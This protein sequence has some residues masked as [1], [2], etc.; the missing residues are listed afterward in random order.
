MKDGSLVALRLHLQSEDRPPSSTRVGSRGMTLVSL[1][2][3][4]GPLHY[5]RE[6]GKQCNRRSIEP[7]YKAHGEVHE[8]DRED[9]YEGSQYHPRAAGPSR[10]LHGTL[11]LAVLLMRAHQLE[12]DR[13][14]GS[15]G[16]Q[17]VQSELAGKRRRPRLARGLGHGRRIANAQVGAVADLCSPLITIRG[18]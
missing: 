13:D 9:C 3:L 1:V 7:D 4:H 5:E 11:L 10:S 15:K 2:P 8:R 6:E 18:R 17:C 16:F 12:W 14:T